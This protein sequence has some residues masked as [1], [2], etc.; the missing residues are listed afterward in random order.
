KLAYA[1]ES[2]R[3]DMALL[4]ELCNEIEY[5]PV[6]FLAVDVNG[7]PVYHTN[8]VMSV[9]THHVIVCMDAVTD[10]LE[11]T[12]LRHTIEK[13]GKRLVEISYAQMSGFAGNVLQVTNTSNGSVWLMSE[14]AL[15]AFTDNQ[16]NELQKTCSA[17]SASIPTIETLGGGSLRCMLAGIHAPAK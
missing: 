17:V 11:K 8:V 5:T 15:N 7:M 14:T 16:I 13:T 1:C 10:V 9:G 3:T 2:P 12:M 4:R 6:S